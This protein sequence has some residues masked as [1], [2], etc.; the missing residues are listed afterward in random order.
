MRNIL[1]A[2]VAIILFAAC[3]PS[4]EDKA[5]AMIKES[6]TNTLFF[7]ESYKP[8]STTIDSAFAPYDDP[9][10]YERTLRVSKLIFTVVNYEKKIKDAKRDIAMYKDFLRISFSNADQEKLNQATEEYQ[11]YVS[12]K[13]RVLQKVQELFSELKKEVEKKPQFIGF[14]AF[15]NYN[16][17]NNAGQMVGGEA[18]FV[19]DKDMK[20]VM[21]EYD[22]G[23]DEYKAV[24]LIYQR[25]RG[26]ETFEESFDL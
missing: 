24:M 23:T 11:E 3:V 14:K 15:H 9:V 13:E 5:N 25:L 20:Q 12:E 21:G 26:E 2:I 1:I 22:T 17:K 4:P 8:V 6:L 16:A 18:L 7:P 19:F 10:F